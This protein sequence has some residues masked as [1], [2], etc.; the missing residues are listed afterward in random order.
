MVSTLQIEIMRGK[1]LRRPPPARARPFG[2]LRLESLHDGT[3]DPFLGAEEVRRVRVDR[4][5]PQ[6]T[7]ARRVDELRRDTKARAGRSD[8]AADDHRRVRFGGRVLDRENPQVRK[9][10]QVVNDLFP[11]TQTEGIQLPSG[12]MIQEGEDADRVPA[13]Q[14]RRNRSLGEGGRFPP[15]EHRRVAAFRQVD[16]HLVAGPFLLVI[17]NQLGA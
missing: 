2:K 13:D 7:A 14:R 6:V 5:G 17:A 11:Y 8:A 1:I 10:G 4:L 3:R 9:S 15:L 16:D 12:A